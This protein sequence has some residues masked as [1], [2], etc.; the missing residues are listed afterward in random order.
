[1][2]RPTPVAASPGFS[3][4]SKRNEAIIAGLVPASGVNEVVD[5]PLLYRCLEAN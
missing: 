2:S 3:W 1:M 4:H 5:G